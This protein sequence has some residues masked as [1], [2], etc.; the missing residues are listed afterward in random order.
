MRYI[1]A[2]I[3][4]FINLFMKIDKVS[5][6][7]G[8]RN[9]L[10]WDLLDRDEYPTITYT[11]FTKHTKL[12]QK[13]YRV[14]FCSHFIEHIDDDVFLN[15]LDE[16][17]KSSDGNT[18][19]FFKYPNFEM[20][21]D[22]FHKDDT[23]DNFLEITNSQYAPVVGTWA[24]NNVK[25]NRINRISMM[26]CDYS[27]FTFGNPYLTKNNSTNDKSYHGPAKISEKKLRAIF[28]EKNFKK[29]SNQLQFFCLKDKD[30]HMFNH[31]N[32]WHITDLKKILIEKNF[33]IIS[34][35]PKQIFN[36]FKN[37][38]PQNEILYLEEWSHLIYLKI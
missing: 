32:P 4:K 13:K 23:E 2:Y 28:K 6:G 8:R 37:D 21:Y 25:D 38:I 22:A 30:F 35:D 1:K 27:N 5:I 16:I 14:I 34:Q 11:S 7:S 36:E 9:W 18:K 15:L 29:I 10:G 33:K 26:F 31:I 19:I 12:K 24:N 20:F 3:V 17:K